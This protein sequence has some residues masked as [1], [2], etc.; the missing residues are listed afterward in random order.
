MAGNKMTRPAYVNLAEAVDGV[1]H[2]KSDLIDSDEE[3]LLWRWCGWPRLGEYFHSPL[4][5]FVMIDS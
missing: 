2:N 1:A 4:E 5:T 3:Y